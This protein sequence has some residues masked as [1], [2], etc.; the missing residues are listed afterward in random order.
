MEKQSYIVGVYDDEGP[1]IKAAEALKAAGIPIEEA[2]TPYPIHEILHILGRKS[3]LSVAAYIYGWIGGIGI[4]AFMQYAAVLN[5]PLNYGGKPMNS[6]PSFILVT[7]V[8]TILFVTIMSL[9]TFIA[10]AQIFPGK[11]IDIVDAR[12]TD[13][14]FVLVFSPDEVDNSKLESMLKET[15]ASEVYER[16][17]TAES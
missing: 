13:D 1:L 16:K 3:R 17:G 12:A 7:V 5:W 8:F 11:K 14:K 10:R 4:L 6:F 9:T 2:Y 15:G